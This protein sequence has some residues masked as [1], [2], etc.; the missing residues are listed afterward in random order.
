MKIKMTNDKWALIALII[1]LCAETLVNY[2]EG[3]I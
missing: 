3:L 2:A 1:L